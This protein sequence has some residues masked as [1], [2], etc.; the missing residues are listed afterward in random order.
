MVD[1]EN[2]IL[3]LLR[4]LRAEIP[5][6]REEARATEVRVTERLD[7][8]EK[9]LDAMHLNG[10]KALKGVI[11]QATLVE[12]TM[13]SFDDQVS[14]LELRVTVLEDVRA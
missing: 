1:P 3:V 4:E 8:M 9:R 10:T 12:R 2:M 5:E 7:R 13:A 11:G 6:A 14:R